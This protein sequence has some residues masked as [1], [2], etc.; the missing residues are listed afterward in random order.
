VIEYKNLNNYQF[1]E[2]IVNAFYLYQTKTDQFP[3]FLLNGSVAQ[4]GSITYP[5]LDSKAN[6][7]PAYL[8]PSAAVL[9]ALTS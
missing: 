5:K 2:P 8:A 6:T 3:S 7:P 9:G 4:I 1:I